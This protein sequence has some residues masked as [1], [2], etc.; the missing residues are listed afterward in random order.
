MPDLMRASLRLELS[1]GE[2]ACPLKGGSVIAMGR[3]QANQKETAAAGKAC[4]CPTYQARTGFKP[5]LEPDGDVADSSTSNEEDQEEPDQVAAIV[6]KYVAPRAPSSAPATETSSATQAGWHAFQKRKEEKRKD[7]AAARAA[8]RLRQEG[9]LTPPA[10]AKQDR[11]ALKT[12]LRAARAQRQPAELPAEDT[13]MAD[14]WMTTEEIT[15]LFNVSPQLPGQWYQQGKLGKKREKEGRSWKYPREAVMAFKAARDGSASEVG[16][17]A[18][19]ERARAAAAPAN[20]SGAADAVKALRK[21]CWLI[22]GH[23]DGYIGFDQV[24]AGADSSEVREVLG[25]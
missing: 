3:C 9:E 11:D 16:G 25:E 22:Q 4:T 12:A 10:P 24:A 17:G 18:A 15:E 14:Q 6:K 23:R 21:L 1:D 8:E 7:E 19:P 2:I 13:K 20:G 5:E